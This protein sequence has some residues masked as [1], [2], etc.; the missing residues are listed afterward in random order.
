MLFGTK[1]T[2]IIVIGGAASNDIASG[3]AKELGVPVS[4]LEVK[5]LPDGE[6]YIRVEGDVKGK[7]VL[8]VQ[9]TGPPQDK[10][11]IELLITIDAIHGLGA[12][13]VV[14]IIPYLAYARQNKRFRNGEAISINAVL[15]LIRSAGADAIINV[16]PHRR[17]ISEAFKGRFLCV[18]PITSL[19]RNLPTDLK[20]PVLIAPDNGAV[21]RVKK[22]AKLLDIPYFLIEKKRDLESGRI[23]IRNV[24]DFDFKGNDAVIIDDIV[25]TG[26]TVL[27]AAIAAKDRGAGR[28]LVVAPHLIMSGNCYDTL[29]RY[30]I[31]DII[32][33]N[34]IP[35]AN[36]KIVDISQD[37][38]RVAKKLIEEIR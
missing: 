2:G 30:G 33:S 10:H 22:A 6:S 7:I 3:I 19:L 20:A 29:R 5:T 1:S 24:Q 21:E 18:D 8:L 23:T 15:K 34:S 13:K 27:A 14:A 28:V 4:N 17:E 32:G 26:K 12:K 16:E 11:L 36:A 25:S 38:A 31:T 37:I 9:S 35:N